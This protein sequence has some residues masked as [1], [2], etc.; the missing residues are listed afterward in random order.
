MVVEVSPSM[1]GEVCVNEPAPL[2]NVTEPAAGISGT[3]TPPATPD[4]PVWM[5]ATVIV[6]PAGNPVRLATTVAVA[7][8]M[9]FDASLVTSNVIVALPAAVDSAFEMGGTS[10]AA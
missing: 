10:L 3:R 1:E 4:A 5:C 9:V 2:V 6:E 8:V 7:L